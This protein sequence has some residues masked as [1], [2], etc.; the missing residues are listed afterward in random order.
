MYQRKNTPFELTP[1]NDPICKIC[2]ADE[3]SHLRSIGETFSEQYTSYT[4]EDGDVCQTFRSDIN[5]KITTWEVVGYYKGND[6]SWHEE[7]KRI[8]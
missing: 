2:T 8:D 6:G 7:L 3:T 4:R 5:T 1:C